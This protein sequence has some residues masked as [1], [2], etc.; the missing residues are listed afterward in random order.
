MY[1]ITANMEGKTT[2]QPADNQDNYY[3]INYISHKGT[4]APACNCFTC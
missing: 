1:G 3:N 4:T 2:K